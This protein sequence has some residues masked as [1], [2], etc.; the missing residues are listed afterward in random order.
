MLKD[1]LWNSFV[2]D[3]RAVLCQTCMETR[4]N[5]PLIRD[6]LIICLFNHWQGWRW[7]HDEILA[8]EGAPA[9]YLSVQDDI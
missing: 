7:T 6:D 5:R 2:F 8:D 3:K 1:E 9:D 4:L